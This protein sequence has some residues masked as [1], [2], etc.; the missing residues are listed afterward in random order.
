MFLED[1]QVWLPK[2]WQTEFQ[3]RGEILRNYTVIEP[4]SVEIN[5]PVTDEDFLPQ[6]P[7]GTIVSD[8]ITGQVY[9]IADSGEVGEI[10]YEGSDDEWVAVDAPVATESAGQADSISPAPRHG[11]RQAWGTLAP[12]FDSLAE[13]TEFAARVRAAERPEG[14]EY[15]VEAQSTQ[16]VQPMPT[17]APAVHV[18]RQDTPGGEQPGQRPES[19]VAKVVRTRPSES[20]WPR[21]VGAA[22]V[23]ALL[24]IGCSIWR[25]S[26][27]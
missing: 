14:N 6:F 10:L 26:P 11:A 12:L 4:E 8:Q 23:V 18:G 19:D 21:I 13:I 17:T 25:R 9:R 7:P 3:A 24:G 1:E 2:S 22:A 27:A 16:P 15:E 5:P 20:P